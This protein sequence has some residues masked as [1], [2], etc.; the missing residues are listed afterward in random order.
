MPSKRENIGHKPLVTDIKWLEM[1]GKYGNHLAEDALFVPK[2]LPQLHSEGLEEH[3]PLQVSPAEFNMYSCYC[4][5]WK[6]GDSVQRVF[7]RSS[8]HH[9][10]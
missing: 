3:F 1:C 5:R 10:L 2:K 8:L 9:L 7:K 6:D 4:T